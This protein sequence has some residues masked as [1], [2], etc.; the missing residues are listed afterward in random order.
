MI[1]PP[2]RDISSPAVYLAAR[3]GQSGGQRSLSNSGQLG[4]W[5]PRPFRALGERA[6]ASSI[7]VRR[8]FPLWR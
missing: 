6:G 3:C 2:Y 8:S 7:I 1:R 5:V 4:P